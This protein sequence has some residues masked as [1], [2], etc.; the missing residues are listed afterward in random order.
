M[1]YAIMTKIDADL[2]IT[3]TTD[4]EVKQRWFPLA[5]SLGYMPALEAAH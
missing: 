4:P 1:T 5:I 3:N 2:N